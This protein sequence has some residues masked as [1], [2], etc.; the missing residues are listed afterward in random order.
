MGNKP[1]DIQRGQRANAPIPTEGQSATEF[2]AS[3]FVLAL[4]LMIIFDFGRGLY[5][6]SVISAAAQE[7]ARYGLIH[8]GDTAGI[9]NAARSRVVGLEPTS[10]IIG[11]T[12][13]ES[14]VIAVTVTYEFQAV[15]P[16]IGQLLGNRGRLRLA[17][18]AAMRQ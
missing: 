11:V 5:A 4:F 2:A 13:P 7:G 14:N 1:R 10:L 3:L 6:Y 9:Q 17:A 12:W 15:T 18:T 16:L 8:P